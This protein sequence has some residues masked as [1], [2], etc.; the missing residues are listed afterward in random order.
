MRRKTYGYSYYV[1]HYYFHIHTLR[2]SVSVFFFFQAE[3]GIRDYKV[4]GVQTCA[5]PISGST[6]GG[7]QH[8]GS[9]GDDLLRTQLPTAVTLGRTALRRCASQRQAEP[10]RHCQLPR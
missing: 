2:I 8:P 4:T 3:D 7:G 6:S 5:L 1:S 10:A 9:Q